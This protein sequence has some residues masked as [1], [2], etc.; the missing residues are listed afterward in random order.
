MTKLFTGG[1]PLSYDEMQLAQLFGP[2][3]DIDSI[4]IVR[5]KFSGQSKGFAFIHMKT[6]E[7]AAN[8]AANLDGYDF[9]E[10]KL[11]VRLAEEKPKPPVYKKISANTAAKPKRPRISR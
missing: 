9:G 6:A 5:D 10:R 7:G 1:F 2:Y 8:A 3:G 4:T 11:E